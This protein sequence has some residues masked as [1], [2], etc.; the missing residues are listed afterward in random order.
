MLCELLRS[1]GHERRVSRNADGKWARAASGLPGQLHQRSDSCRPA[2][3]HY[4]AGRVIVCYLNYIACF[5]LRLCTEVGDQGV[6]QLEDGGHAAGPCFARARHEFAA[7]PCQANGGGEI[8]TPRGYERAV[9]AQAVAREAAGCRQVWTVCAESSPGSDAGR[10]ERRL[11]I[12][13]V[14]EEFGW[15]CEAES[16]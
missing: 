16:R 11:G 13:R 7:R 14:G 6:I 10:E 12:T 15:A 8:E 4:L 2:G 1:R 5:D 9:F 3:H